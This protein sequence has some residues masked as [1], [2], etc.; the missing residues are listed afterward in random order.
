MGPLATLVRAWSAG[1]EIY[2]TGYGPF[3]LSNSPFGSQTTVGRAHPVRPACVSL[4][5]KATE[6][7]CA[8][9]PPFDC[10]PRA[11]SPLRIFISLSTAKTHY[12]TI[13]IARL[14]LERRP[15][16]SAHIISHLIKWAYNRPFS[17]WVRWTDLDWTNH[18]L[19][20]E[21]LSFLYAGCGPKVILSGQL[22]WSCAMQTLHCGQIWLD[23]A[24]T[25]WAFLIY[26]TWIR[27]RKP[28]YRPR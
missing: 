1:G 14:T 5:S 12:E 6:A 26:P 28:Q 8:P 27:F 4:I 16:R 3:H 24:A 13:F 7:L 2:A 25:S 18:N 10:R 20:N 9:L 17:W 11:P 23:L 19:E 21:L 15:N 22:L